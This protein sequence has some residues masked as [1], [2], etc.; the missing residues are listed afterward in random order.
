MI[1]LD[2]IRLVTGIVGHAHDVAHVLVASHSEVAALAPIRSPW[3]ADEP[4]FVAA[5]SAVSN[6]RDAVIWR[7]VDAWW[8][9]DDSARIALEVGWDVDS[10]S[11]WA[12]ITND[13][14]FCFIFILYSCLSDDLLIF[15]G[16]FFYTVL[17]S[18][19]FVTLLNRLSLATALVSAYRQYDRLP[20]Y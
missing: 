5:I 4:V 11:Y 15:W 6:N 14:K 19:S 9:V 18:S 8:V 16:R 17:R 2:S 10:N 13:L 20:V 1:W 7:L 3:V 12:V